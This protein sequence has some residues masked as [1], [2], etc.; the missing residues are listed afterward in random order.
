MHTVI[1]TPTFTR[2]AERALMTAS[3]IFA[4]ISML[5][6]EPDQGDEISG[7]G[8]CRKVRFA[9]KGKGKSG[10]YRV[11]TFY[12]GENIPVFLITVFAKGRKANLNKAECNG[13]RQMTRVLLEAYLR[14]HSNE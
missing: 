2:A 13:L 5:G 6:E 10:G 1:E 11:I 14:G 7:T 9:G 12:S 4:I 8:G 3:E